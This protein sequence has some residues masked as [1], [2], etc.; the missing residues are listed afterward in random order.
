M[1]PALLFLSAL[2]ALDD[3]PQW[4]G[5][6]GD[7]VW[8][9]S[10][11]VRDLPPGLLPRVWSAPIGEGYAGPA[12]AAGKVFVTDL[13]ER[14]GRNAKERAL[15]LDAA[16]G[17]L[18][19]THEWAVEY[20]IQYPAGPRATPLVDGDRVVVLGAVGDLFCL[21]VGSGTVVWKKNLPA[22]F[23]AGIATW[24]FAAA[25]I[26]DGDR[27]ICLVGGRKGALVVAFDKATGKELWRSLEDPG[28][29]YCPPQIATLG[30]LRQLI[31]W[32]PEA[33]SS[34]DPADGKPI[35]THP[36]KIRS[37]LCV[38]SPRAVGDRLFLTAFYDGPL[39][40]EAAPGGRS[41]RV[42]WQGA[43]RSEQQT[44]GLHSIMPTPW[45]TESHVYGIC[46][47]GQL[48]GLDAKTGKRLWETRQPTGEGRWWNA[49]LVPHEDRFFIH[50]EQGDLIVATLS[51][52]GYKETSRAKLV[53]PTRKVQNRMTI[54]SHPAFAMKSVF[55]RNDKELVRVDLSAK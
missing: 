47:Y 7:L 54:W 23:E 50:N 18:L 41:V 3:W 20:G 12:V 29:G 44:D 55:A 5:P 28:V 2:P 6:K 1:V 45:V 17:K 25:P 9:E 22:D 30:G 19:W 13:V 53:E 49:F 36:W 31:V 42:V 10:G 40:L 37:G 32:H 38:P 15:C 52:E 43:S 39:M 27:L 11:I 8:R 48:R 51:P 35:W 21:E 14:R 46:S 4:G 24:G 33:V 34:I 26:L 16:T